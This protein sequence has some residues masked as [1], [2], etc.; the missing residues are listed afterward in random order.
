MEGKRREFYDE[1]EAYKYQKHL[2]RKGIKSGVF[3]AYNW[4][5]QRTIYSVVPEVIE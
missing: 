1:N 5:E 3:P 2:L 4:S